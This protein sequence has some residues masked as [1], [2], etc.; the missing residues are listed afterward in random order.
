MNKKLVAVA[1]A[2]LLAAPLAQAQ[3]ANV[4][5]YGRVNLD[6]E[7][8]N[9]K[10]QSGNT[11]NPNCNLPAPAPQNVSCNNPNVFRVSS[12]S[13][14]FGLRGT[15][16][17]GGGLSAIFQIENSVSADASGGTIAARETFVGLQGGWGTVKLGNFLSPYDDIHP[18]FGSV[19][20]LLTSILATGAHWAQASES[21][22]N[23]GFDNRNPNSVRYDSP[24]L[25][26]FTGSIQ[27]SAG[28][29]VPAEYSSGTPSAP[30]SNS[31]IWS[32]GGFYNNGPAQFGVAYNRNNNVRAAGLDDWAF[33]I[34]GGWQ[35]S[36]WRI[37]AVWERLEYDVSNGCATGVTG[38]NSL[39]RDFWLVGA[40][41]NLGPGQLYASWGMAYDGKGSAPDGTRVGRLTKGNDT[42][43]DQW[44]ISY[45]YPLSKRTLTYIGYSKVIN[46]ANA[47]YTFNVNSY[48]VVNGGDPGGFVMG[49]VHFF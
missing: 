41:I 34:A 24:S 21:N 47:N 46:D 1:V 38:C 43:S 36:G 42:S 12:N 5:L 23:G 49:T 32:L 48:N 6:M 22:A 10:Q 16:A 31:G 27:Y 2:G 15:E 7:V 26:G 19:P 28:G 4:T 40:T 8:V 35:F 14:R 3:T 9:G 44:T 11:L 39:K 17:L 37:G 33:S 29:Q 13:S 20:T 18:I 45:T 25:S 30:S